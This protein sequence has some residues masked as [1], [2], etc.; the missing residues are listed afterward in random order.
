V[1]CTILYHPDIPQKGLPRI[2]RN[3]QAR[4]ADALATRLGGSPE[5]YGRPLCCTLGGYWKL[6]VGD[7]RAL[8]KIVRDEVWG[9]ASLHR[10]QVYEDALRRVGWQPT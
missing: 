5:K 10:R 4:P 9:L 8:F 3:V 1:P 6:K 2:P 7:Y